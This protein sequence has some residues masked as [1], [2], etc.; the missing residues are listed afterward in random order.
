MAA[1]DGRGKISPPQ[2]FDPWTAQFVGSRYA[3]FVI[4]AF[5]IVT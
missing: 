2:V 1:M 3:D 5:K 4:P